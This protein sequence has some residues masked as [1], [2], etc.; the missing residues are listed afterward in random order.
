MVLAL[1]DGERQEEITRGAK[2]VVLTAV[3]KS[4][5]GGSGV[6][7]GGLVFLGGLRCWRGREICDI[8]FSKGPARKGC[9][10]RFRGQLLRCHWDLRLLSSA[11]ITSHFFKTSPL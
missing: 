7:E 1:L 3:P 6:G 2:A 10:T 8:F 11:C 4:R 9:R 5:C